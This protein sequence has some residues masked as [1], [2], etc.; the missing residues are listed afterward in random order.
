VLPSRLS[1]YS[2][3]RL[4]VGRSSLVSTTQRAKK[5]PVLQQPL[6]ALG[7]QHPLQVHPVAAPAGRARRRRQHERGPGQARLG[8]GQLDDVE[9]GDADRL[10][11][12]LPPGDRALAGGCGPGSVPLVVVTPS[13]CTVI[14]S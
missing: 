1:S 13:T 14:G 6:G 8:Y 12:V 7:E 4:A 9:R 10:L 11:C 5:R 3:S 2:A